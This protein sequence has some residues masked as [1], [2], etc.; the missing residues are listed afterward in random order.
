MKR[1]GAIL[2][3]AVIAVGFAGAVK[4]ASKLLP[5]GQRLR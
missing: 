4:A 2:P 3:E 1:I 5:F